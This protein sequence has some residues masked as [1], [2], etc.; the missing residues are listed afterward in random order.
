MPTAGDEER[1][2]MSTEELSGRVALVT[3]AASGLGRAVATALAEAGATVGL[4]DIDTEGAEKTRAQIGRGGGV[5]ALDVTDDGA[6]RRVIADLFHRHGDAFD[7]L[8]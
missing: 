6:R 8:V 5:V 3:G 2:Q 4:G 1:E 7:L